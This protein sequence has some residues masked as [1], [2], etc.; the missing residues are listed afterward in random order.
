MNPRKLP[1]RATNFGEW[2]ASLGLL[3]LV[4]AAAEDAPKLS[5]DNDGF[6]HLHSG[7][8]DKTLMSLLK[9]ST[10]P[11]KIRVHFYTK[12]KAKGASSKPISIGDELHHEASFALDTDANRK[13]FET[14]AEAKDGCL[15][16]FAVGRGVF[17]RHFVGK[18]LCELADLR[19]PVKTWSGQVTFPR[20]FLSIRE[21]V[22]KSAATSFDELLATSSRE[23]QRFRFDHAWEN[24]FDDGS[25]SLE[26]GAEMRPA[27]EWLALVGLSFFPSEWGWKCLSPS[28]NVLRSHVW[29]NPLDIG[30]ATL[31]IHSGQLRPAADFQVVVGGQFE[32]KKIR[33]LSNCN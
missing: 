17:V 22:A 24:Y 14:T 19:S 33:F 7:A 15:V 18:A 1:L 5:F 23:T 4:A 13:A 12:T 32:P 25:A 9:E 16:T 20:I 28:R 3:Q 6:A 10:D 29:A 26:E 8:D 27:V 30:A 11:Q 2:L 31:A 21:K